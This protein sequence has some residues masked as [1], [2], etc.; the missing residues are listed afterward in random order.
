VHETA[1][2]HTLSGAVSKG[3]AAHRPILRVG[4]FDF[5][6]FLLVLLLPAPLNPPYCRS[7]PNFPHSLQIA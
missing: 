1:G 7:T 5:A 4:A 2:H 3:R 6:F